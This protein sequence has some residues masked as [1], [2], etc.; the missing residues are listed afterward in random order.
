MIIAVNTRLNKKMQPEGYEAYLFSMLEYLA[1][2]FPQYKFLYIF[3]E[4]VNEKLIFGKNVQ[5]V[6]AGPKTSSSLRLQYWFNYK[7]PAV[8]RK[9]KA[10]IFVSMEGIGSLRTNVPQCLLIS[11]LGFISLSASV[12][13]T[14]VRFYKKYTAAYLAK[15]KVIAAISEYVQKTIA[16]QYKI[17][18]ENITV[19]HPAIDEIFKPLDWEAQEIVREK[20]ANGKAYYLCSANSN[21]I[22]LLKAFTFFKK[23]QKSSML[24]LITGDTDES[25]KKE[26][27]TYKLREEVKL[28]EQPDKTELAKLTAAAYAVVHPVLYD[29][30]A[31][32]ALQALQCQVPLVISETGSLPSIFGE[33]ALYVNPEN[34]ED[35]AQKMMLVFK[36]EN[37]AKELVETGNKLIKDYQLDKNADLLMDCI[38]KAANS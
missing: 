7:I 26:F 31:L 4:P 8:L 27:K 38:L 10:D 23:R 13:K 18:T 3:D 35:I 9:N 19:V 15:A 6:V 24:L 20:Y 16:D 17:A 25:F 12:K 33:A 11:D 37:R 28:L 5:P 34:F 2:K 29:D 14:Q 22:N 36:D 32:P 1:A 21:L 30:I